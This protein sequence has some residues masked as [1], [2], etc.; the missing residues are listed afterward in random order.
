LD[1][2]NVRVQLIRQKDS[3]TRSKIR[4]MAIYSGSERPGRTELELT[5]PEELCDLNFS[6]LLEQ[7]KEMLP[8]YLV[9]THGQRDACCARYGPSMYRALE[10]RV[11]ARAWQSTHLGGHR[12]APTVIAF[13][14]GNMFGQLTAAQAESLIEGKEGDALPHFRGRTCYSRPVQTA[15]WIIRKEEGLYVDAPLTLEASVQSSPT[16]WSVRFSSERK[17]YAAQVEARTEKSPSGLSCGAPAGMKWTR[18]RAI[19]LESEVR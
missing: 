8:L 3:R 18:Y 13:P 16:T 5:D 4:F 12:F 9:C 14:Q 2:P 15:D 7:R 6:E 10:A 1:R 17:I 19:Q 11:E